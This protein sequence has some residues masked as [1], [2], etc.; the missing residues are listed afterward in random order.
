MAK[1]DYYTV[2]GVAKS[3]SEAEIKLAYRKLARQHHPD[4]DKSAGASER[5]KEVSEA[6]QVLSDV[7]KRKTYDQFG[8]AAFQA[9]GSGTGAGGP[10]GEGGF[11][12]FGGGARS[13]SYSTGGGNPNVEFDF[14]GFEDPFDLFSQIFGGMNGQ[15]FS[16]F[17]KRRPMYQMNLTFEEAVHGVSKEI[18]IERPDGQTPRRE[19]LTVKVP[20]G[21]DNGTRMRFGEVELVFNVRRH[22]EFVREGSDIFTEKTL[23]VPQLVLGTTIDVKSVDGVVKLKVPAGAEPGSLIRI[24]GRGV[25]SVRGGAKGDHF[26]RIRLEVPKNLSSEEHRLYEQLAILSGKKKGWF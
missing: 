26:V 23:S 8:H 10:F 12:P 2:L 1:R 24:K 6:Y 16:G 11:N 22:P 5:F 9:G 21:V 3:A 15:G 7:S 14:S 4:V 19:R 20:A 13:Y 17:P 25:P 18:E